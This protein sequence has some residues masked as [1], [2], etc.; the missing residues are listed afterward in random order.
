MSEV[1]SLER[2]IKI[3]IELS[4]E[5]NFD[6]LMSKIL[7]EAMD[8]CHCDAG[9]VYVLEDEFLQLGDGACAKAMVFHLLGGVVDSLQS[10]ADKR[11]VGVVLLYL[12]MDEIV[13]VV[14]LAGLAEKHVLH[15]GLESVLEPFQAT[16]PHHFDTARLV[17]EK[18][19]GACGPW[20]ANH[21]NVGNRSNQLVINTVII[22]IGH[23]LDLASVDVTERKLVEHI[24]I[25]EHTKFLL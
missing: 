6:R 9:T 14:E 4:A 23:L 21:L 17:A 13:V 3:A 25:G 19:S 2:M 8:I 20:C 18:A 15:A 1:Y 5:K 24:L 7:L 12:G 16:E 11:V 10:L 22:D